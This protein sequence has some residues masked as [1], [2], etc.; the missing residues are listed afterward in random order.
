MKDF[1]NFFLSFILGISILSHLIKIFYLIFKPKFLE[2]YKTFS[3]QPS[4]Y[5]LFLYYLLTIIV[6]IYVIQKRTNFLG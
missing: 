1:S 5:G 2:K 4:K 3:G 6:C